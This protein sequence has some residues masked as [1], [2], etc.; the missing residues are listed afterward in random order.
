MDGGIVTLAMEQARDQKTNSGALE[1]GDR[2]RFM[3]AMLT[4]LRAVE[5]MLA[6]GMFEKGVSRIGAEQEMFLVDGAFNASPTAIELLRKL[7]DDTHYTTELGLF[8]LELNSDPQPLAGNGLARIEAHLGVLYD[9]VKR[10]AVDLGVQPVLTGILPTLGPTDLALR[11]MVPNQRYL[12]LNRVMAAVRG[13]AY[14]ISIKGLDELVTKLDSLMFEAC[15]ASFQVHLQV[16]D[17]ARFGHDYDVSQLLLAPTLALG[18]NSSVLFGKRLWAETR[19]SLFEQSCDTRARA[20]HARER[21]ARVTFGRGWLGQ[22]GVVSLFKENITRFRPL[23]GI[24]DAQDAM[25]VLEDGGVPDLQAL[26]LHNG[27]IYRWNR[28]CYGI[29]ENGK[30]HLRVELRVLPSGPSI[31]DEVANA[32]FW[33]GC[34][35][36]LTHTIEDLPSRM[37]FDHA[38]ANFYAA[39]RD[40][41]AARFTW[42]DG[43][44][45]I[46]Q[47]FILDKLL[48][49]AEAGLARAGVDDASAK[50]YLKVVEQRVRSLRTGAR[51]ALRSL[52]GMKGRGSAGERLTALVAATIARQ[53]SGRPVAEWERARLDEVVA[54]RP[55]NHKVSQYMQTDVITVQA[56]DP[57]ELVAELVAWEDIRHLPVEDEAGNLVGLVTSRAVL[58]HLSADATEEPK[59]GDLAG[60]CVGDIMRR[61]VVTVTPDTSTLDAIH[62]MRDHKIGCLPVVQ[63]GR[64]VAIV[65][66]EDFM[67]IPA[68]SI[69]DDSGDVN[70]PPVLPALAGGR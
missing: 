52:A 21:S 51:W 15:N 16:S 59:S 9:N 38:Q 45:V 29:S 50:R 14:D 32:A 1:G 12:T 18:T 41:L 67:S 30:P 53:S 8:N 34:M 35:S 70:T 66:E 40:G 60:T 56:D 7:D 65:T 27:T 57:L 44:E 64:I 26:R 37:E 13:D 4:D 36:E 31:L 2:R 55:A 47:P 46:A 20:A 23:V 43:K 22:G 68:D 48:P 69:D 17:P 61:L 10:A 54:R 24:Q 63:D 19:I 28:P 49:V 5:H 58:R 33:L 3:R 42:L 11:N 6:H 39:A 62:L 25:A